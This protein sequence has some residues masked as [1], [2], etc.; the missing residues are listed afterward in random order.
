MVKIDLELAQPSMRPL[1]VMSDSY[2][3]RIGR[4]G[5][6]SPAAR[7]LVTPWCRETGRGVPPCPTLRLG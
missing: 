4:C 2:A 5:L 3:D 7:V 6:S 1:G